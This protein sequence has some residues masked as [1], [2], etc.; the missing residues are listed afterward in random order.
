MPRA[1]CLI[2]M[3]RGKR[4][5]SVAAMEAAPAAAARPEERVAAG[6]RLPR[7]SSVAMA[8]WQPLPLLKLVKMGSQVLQRMRERRGTRVPL[9]RLA[10]SAKRVSI[11]SAFN[12]AVLPVRVAHK[13]SPFSRAPLEVLA[14]PEGVLVIT[15]SATQKTDGTVALARMDCRAALEEQA[16]MAVMEAVGRTALLDSY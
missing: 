7:V 5:N 9:V 11:I 3:P 13:G 2:L 16:E 6:A 8:V 14:A 15:S 10:L 1:H 12:W 4:P